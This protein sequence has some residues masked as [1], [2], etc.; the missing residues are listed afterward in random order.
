M[1]TNVIKMYSVFLSSSSIIDKI[2]KLSPYERSRRGIKL[3]DRASVQSPYAG[4]ILLRDWGA[5]GRMNF[6]IAL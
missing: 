5:L 6:R 4:K 1:S 3:F 2:L